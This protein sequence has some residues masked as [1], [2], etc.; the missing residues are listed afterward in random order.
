METIDAEDQKLEAVLRLS[1][2]N[3]KAVQVLSKHW[4]VTVEQQNDEIV[5]MLYR[6]E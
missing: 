2:L 3:T 5:I 4:I 6:K 1:E